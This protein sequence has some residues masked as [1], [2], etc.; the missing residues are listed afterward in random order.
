[1]TIRE[2]AILQLGEIRVVIIFLYNTILDELTAMMGQT[3]P[4][5]MPHSPSLTPTLVRLP[6]R[7]RLGDFM[8]L[9]PWGIAIPPEIL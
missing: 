4:A 6:T 7:R 8:I 5:R 2:T 9:T 1:V 3:M